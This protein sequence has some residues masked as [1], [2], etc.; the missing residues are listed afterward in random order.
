Q[1]RSRE[2]TLID[3]SGGAGHLLFAGS[4]RPKS[5]D[6]AWQATGSALTAAGAVQGSVL[7]AFQRWKRLMAAGQ[8]DRRADDSSHRQLLRRA[9]D[10]VAS[11]RRSIEESQATLERSRQAIE[12]SQARL[13]RLNLIVSLRALMESS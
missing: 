3:L 6:P 2:R 1:K 12:K 7:P 4:T 11:T 10:L 13:S 5:L 8:P 9:H